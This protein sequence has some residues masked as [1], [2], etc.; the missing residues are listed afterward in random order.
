[1]LYYD[2]IGINQLF[3]MRYNYSSS[4]FLSLTSCYSFSFCFFILSST[5]FLSR[6][7]S[8]S[9]GIYS[10]RLFSCSSVLIF[11]DRY[12]THRLVSRRIAS[13]L[14]ISRSLSE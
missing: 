10:S 8:S 7:F 11:T 5:P 3:F 14:N 13:S 4:R 6:P 12:Y 1:M 2:G 9:F